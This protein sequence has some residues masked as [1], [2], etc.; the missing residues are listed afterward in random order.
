[1]LEV[2]EDEDEELENTQFYITCESGPEQSAD[3]LARAIVRI[4]YSKILS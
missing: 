3:S 4:A 1:M 2:K